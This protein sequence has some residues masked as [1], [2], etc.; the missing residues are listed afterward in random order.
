MATKKVYFNTIAQLAG[1][2]ST[3]FISIFLIKI[4]TNYLSVDDY[5]LYSKVYNYLSIFAVIA[6]MGL[7]TIT[8]REIS[9]NKDNKAIVQKI[10][11]NMMTI[12]MSLGIAIIF[13]SVGIAY[14][15]PGYNSKLALYSIFITS[16]FVF[17]GLMNS[18]ILSLLQAYLKTEFSF[19]STTVG[20]LSNFAFV[21][22]VIFV[23]FPKAMVASDPSLQFQSFL[24]LMFAGVFG[25]IVMTSIIYMYSRK[26]E[27]ISFGFDLAHIKNLVKTSIPYGI[28]MFLNVV[29][30]KIDVIILSLMEDKNIVNTSIGLYSVP[31]KIVEVGMLFGGLFLQSMLPLFTN[32]I[33]KKESEEMYSLVSRS[34][35][36]LFAFGIAIVGF[37]LANGFGILSLVAN[38]EYLDHT[39]YI[40]NSLDSFNIVVFVFLF[41][42]ISS[43]FT[44][45]LIANNEQ[46]RL[47]KVNFYLTILNIILNVALIPK[48]SFIGSSIATLISQIVML[49]Y[50]YIV[51]RHIF[52]FNFMPSY[53][54]KIIFLGVIASFSNML[55]HNLLHFSSTMSL[56]VSFG[57]F[58]IIFFPG[59]YLAYV[60]TK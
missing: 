40:Y 10:I 60:K 57:I 33:K 51:S 45:I 58:A 47:L 3:A 15:L 24:W 7:F 36:L 41:C 37:S 8:I 59:A 55:L 5:G 50:I 23:L 34:Y 9:A 44:Y 22:L 6:D 18:A 56:I 54:I 27:K 1:K 39:K 16:F 30:F 14:F 42:F 12:R 11:G 25:N 43:I 13:L 32:A 49:V 29:Y 35:K 4:L 52:R 48:F 46:G 20:K 2:V 38:K 21:L 28:A 19:I 26:V 17:F 53:T 31:M